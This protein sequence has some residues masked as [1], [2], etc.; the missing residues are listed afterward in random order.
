MDG[1]APPRA[2]PL[3]A[4]RAS[5]VERSDARTAAPSL[6]PA[7]GSAERVQP[8]A[9]AGLHPHAGRRPAPLLPEPGQRR[10]LG[11]TPA[12]SAAAA[13]A[14]RPA[15]SSQPPRR[16]LT[17]L[18]LPA[19]G[20]QAVL[21]DADV[22][23]GPDP[24][25]RT[26]G[27]SADLAPAWFAAVHWCFDSSSVRGL[28]EQPGA[29]GGQPAHGE[30]PDVTSGCPPTRAHPGACSTLHALHAGLV[31]DP[32]WRRLYLVLFRAHLLIALGVVATAFEQLA[33]SSHPCLPVCALGRLCMRAA[34]PVW[35]PFAC[36]TQRVTWRCCAHAVPAM[37]LQSSVV[38]WASSDA[39]RRLLL[40]CSDRRATEAANPNHRLCARPLTSSPGPWCPSS[41]IEAA[42]GRL[43][44]NPAPVCAPLPLHQPSAVEELR[45][46]R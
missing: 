34:S 36:C 14:P 42:A 43:A 35:S 37:H 30:P 23:C 41:S 24:G 40:R 18:R 9:R 25:M 4:A 31:H 29:V 26:M 32:A 20:A 7:A 39:D 28:E 33:W 19:S 5:C 1:A 3:S 44:A 13:R 6:A 22:P 38:A 11:E 16:Q 17:R 10:H 46:G 21:Y 12:G 2:G 27:V 8:P 45:C 15:N